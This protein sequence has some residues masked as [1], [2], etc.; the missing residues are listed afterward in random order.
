MASVEVGVHSDIAPAAAWELASDLGRFSEWMTIFGGWRGDVPARIEEGTR[1][2]SLIK[3]K[4][5]RNVIH[6]RVT[7]Y[8]EPEVIALAGHGRGGVRITLTMKVTPAGPGSRFGLHADLRGGLLNG[9]V[10]RLVAR[11][12]ESDVRASI[13][14]L[15]QLS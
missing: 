8:V 7:E 13:Q 3:V 10:G 6:W 4:G 11:V 9:P 2:S 12:I 14:N 15:A 5:F 1:I